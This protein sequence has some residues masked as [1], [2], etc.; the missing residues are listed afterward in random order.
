MAEEEKEDLTEAIQVFVTKQQLE[1]FKETGTPV[2]DKFIADIDGK[3]V[4]IDVLNI[5][6][7]FV[8]IQ[9]GAQQMNKKMDYLYNML[10]AMNVELKNAQ[11]R[12]SELEAA[13]VRIVH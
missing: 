4:E 6:P 13:K 3:E 1:L 11:L 2:F 9:D 12:I 8:A 10:N 5:Y 7:L